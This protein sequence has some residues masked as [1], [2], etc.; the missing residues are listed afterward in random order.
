MRYEINKSKAMVAFKLKKPQGIAGTYRLSLDGSKSMTFDLNI[1]CF[2]VY[3]NSMPNPAR[4]EINQNL[5]EA[6]AFSPCHW[7]P[8]V[9]YRGHSSEVGSNAKDLVKC[10]RKF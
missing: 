8:S 7:D 1:P 9:T 4:S 3:S 10:C 2:S 6:D 5:I